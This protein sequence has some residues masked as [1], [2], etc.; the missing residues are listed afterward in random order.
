MRIFSRFT[1]RAV[2]RL[3]DLPGMHHHQGGDLPR[4]GIK[5]PL[6]LM[7]PLT[8]ELHH[9][10]MVDDA[11]EVCV[12]FSRQQLQWPGLVLRICQYENLCGIRKNH[13]WFVQYVFIYVVCI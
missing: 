9:H 8:D 1:P 13:I 10:H 11:D 2:V 7:L 5:W 6:S 4:S 12:H 3:T